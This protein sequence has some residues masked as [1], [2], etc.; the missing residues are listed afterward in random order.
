MSYYLQKFKKVFQK[1]FK[2]TQNNLDEDIKK[3]TTSY[4]RIDDSFL[5]SFVEFTIEDKKRLKN[6]IKVYYYLRS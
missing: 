2:K 5:S 6:T 3:S 1:H 4:K